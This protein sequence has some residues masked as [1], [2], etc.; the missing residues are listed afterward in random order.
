MRSSAKFILPRFSAL[1]RSVHSSCG[2]CDGANSTF[3]SSRALALL[4]LSIFLLN[5]SFFMGIHRSGD[6]QREA[7]LPTRARKISHLACHT[8]RVRT[9]PTHRVGTAER[10]A[11]GSVH[12][13]IHE[14][15]NPVASARAHTPHAC[16]CP[17]SIHRVALSPAKGSVPWTC[18]VSGFC[19]P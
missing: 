2:S 13:D 9:I 17:M 11:L 8:Q 4:R 7:P 18:C 15:L 6:L 1:V 14:S 16:A 19:G 5:F 12:G 3:R 10:P